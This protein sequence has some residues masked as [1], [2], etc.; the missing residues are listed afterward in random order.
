MLHSKCRGRFPKNVDASTKSEFLARCFY[1]SG[2]YDSPDDFTKFD[3]SAHSPTVQALNCV[4]AR[5][6]VEA[7]AGAGSEESAAPEVGRR[8]S[9][10][11]VLPGDPAHH[12]RRS[13]PRHPA[14]CNEQGDIHACQCV[15]WQLRFAIAVCCTLRKTEAALTLRG[16]LVADGLES[17][18]CR[19]AV[20]Q[21]QRVVGR[22]GQTARHALL[23]GPNLPH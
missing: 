19:E 16:A 10:P 21:G 14:G 2:Q 12:F 18:D 3:V 7:I 22:A 15:C 13:R 20:W 5:L 6:R 23:R 4:S 9:E 8:E 1:F 17:R 11:R